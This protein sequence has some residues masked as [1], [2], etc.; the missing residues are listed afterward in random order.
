MKECPTCH[1][2]FESK[3]RICFNCG[4]PIRRRDKWHTTGPYN[5]H[6]D[7]AN[8]ELNVAVE[9]PLLVPQ[10]THEDHT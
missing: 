6:D 9:T 4:R 5:Q 3:G 8:P 10:E 2:P 1:R 7:C